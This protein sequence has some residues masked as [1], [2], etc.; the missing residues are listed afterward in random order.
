MCVAINEK[1]SNEQD[2]RY[3]QRQPFNNMLLERSTKNEMVIIM[4]P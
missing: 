3:W 1:P 2:D 4:T